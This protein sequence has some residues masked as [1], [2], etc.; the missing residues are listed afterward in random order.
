[1]DSSFDKLKLWIYIIGTMVFSVMFAYELSSAI[2]N[3]SSI[4]RTFVPLFLVVNYVFL[5]FRWITLNRKKNLELEEKALTKVKRH[6][7]LANTVFCNA[8]GVL[9]LA[10]ILTDCLVNDKSAWFTAA[11]A[12]FTVCTICLLFLNIKSLKHFTR[13]E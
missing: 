1:M 13:S 12:I 11:V 10:G 7:D 3:N 4:S 2:A 5:V 8:T 6:H 9:L